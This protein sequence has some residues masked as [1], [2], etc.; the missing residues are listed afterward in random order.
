M[1]WS[2]IMAAEPAEQ[3]LVTFRCVSKLFA[4]VTA[5]RSQHIDIQLSFGTSIPIK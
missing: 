1:G 2:H 3:L 4:A 5:I